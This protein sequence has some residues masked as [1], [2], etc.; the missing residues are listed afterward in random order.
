MKLTYRHTLLASYTGYITQAIINNLPPLLFLTFNRQFGVTL[1][2]IGLLVSVNFGIQMAVDILAAHFVDRI[3]YRRCITG[4]HV[5]CVLGLAGFGLFPFIMDPYA[6]ILTAT[7]LNAIGGGLLEV[8]VSPVV[9]ALPGEE[10]AGAMSLLHS[11]YCWGH[12]AVV[13][14][15]T[16]YFALAGISSWRYL[17][18]IWAAVPLTNTFVFAWTPILVPVDPGKAMPIGTLFRSKMFLMLFMM[19]I[20]AGASEQAMSQ[21]SSLFA[22]AGLKVSKSLGDLLGPCTFA[23]LMG[24][25]R[26]VY[27]IKSK[28]INLR[29]ALIA[30][31]LLCVLS[32]LL[33]VFSKSPYL[34]LAGCA[35]CGLSVGI[36]WPGTFSMAA[37]GFPSGGTAMFALLALSGDIGCSIGPG[38]VGFL[39][40]AGENALAFIRF[41][42]P[43]NLSAAQT[44]LRSGLLAAAA[45]PLGM[46]WL[47]IAAKNKNRLSKAGDGSISGS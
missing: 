17:P 39:A 11:F 35:L 1:E 4:A 41:L 47:S 45:F 26:L 30:S 27:G 33:A 21:W 16:L 29:L 8:L 15:S 2:K 9:E 38:L 10:K 36:M 31:S 44:A 42:L 5:F 22:E 25:S 19:M 6:G 23:A 24:L 34:S 7:A 12:V 14:L 20:C 3:G 40:S 46:A 37:K 43:G 32:Y 28:R 18:L 13:L